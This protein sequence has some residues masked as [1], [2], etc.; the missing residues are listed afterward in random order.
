W[1]IGMFRHTSCSYSRYLTSSTPAL[2]SFRRPSKAAIN[3]AGVSRCAIERNRVVLSA[4]ASSVNRS[5]C[6]DMVLD[7]GVPPCIPRSGRPDVHPVPP[8]GSGWTS[9]PPSLVL[10][11][12]KTPPHPSRRSLVSLDRAIPPLARRRRGGLPGSWGIPLRA[13]LGLETPAARRGPRLSVLAML[14]SAE[15]NASASATSYDFGAESARPAPSLSNASPRRSPDAGA[16]LATG[17]LATALTGLDFRQLDSVER[18]HVLIFSS[19][20]PS[21]SWRDDSGDP[22]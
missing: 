4:L 1:S 20:P 7:L 18:F 14:P 2:A 17:L 10:R 11:V 22:N 9:S 13:C 5:S 6:V 15:S 21:F 16:R 19:P 8:V 12:S 3:A